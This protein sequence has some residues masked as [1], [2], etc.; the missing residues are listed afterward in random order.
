MHLAVEHLSIVVYCSRVRGD[1]CD[2]LYCSRVRGDGCE[3]VAGDMMV[4]EVL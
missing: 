2:V 1:G 3:E 4:G